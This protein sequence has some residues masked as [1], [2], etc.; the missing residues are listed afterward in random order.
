MSFSRQGFHSLHHPS[1]P[2][3][4]LPRFPS[5]ASSPSSN[6]SQ[7]DSTSAPEFMLHACIPLPRGLVTVP[8]FNLPIVTRGRKERERIPSS[9]RCCD[10]RERLRVERSGMRREVQFIPLSSQ[11]SFL[12]LVLQSHLFSRIFLSFLLAPKTWRNQPSSLMQIGSSFQLHAFHAFISLSRCGVTYFR[13][14]ALRP[15]PLVAAGR[16][17]RGF[18]AQVLRHG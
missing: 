10:R 7:A 18:R 9:E 11:I 5:P 16:K 15:S 3:L 12:P 8:D 2:P 1:F 13:L 4:P 14:H 6:Q 17:K